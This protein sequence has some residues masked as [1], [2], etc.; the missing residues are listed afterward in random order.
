MLLMA[1]AW[2]GSAS[3]AEVSNV[4]KPPILTPV[5]LE[6]EGVVAEFDFEVTKHWIYEFEIR[7][8]YPEKD[9]SERSRIRKIIGGHELDKNSD[10][11]DPGVPTPVKL[12]IF[13]E[14][15]HS[16]ALVYKKTITPTLTS[17]GGDN[18][19]K[20]IG[21]CDL[22]PGKYRVLLESL[23]SHE[24][25]ASVPSFFLIGADTFKFSFDPRKIDRNKTC[26]Q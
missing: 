11:I 23:S 5:R 8:K 25:Y 22:A 12:T 7:F 10:P 20:N 19:T 24:E 6:R 26:P 13:R 18:F 21:H 14:G 3:C 15:A 17:W 1:L 9:Q 2:V 4:R 16:K